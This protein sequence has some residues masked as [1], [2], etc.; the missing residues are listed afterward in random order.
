MA[1]CIRHILLH[2][3]SENTFRRS[4]KMNLDETVDSYRQNQPGRATGA[5]STD[6]NYLTFEPL[7][8]ERVWGGRK[9]AALFGR[10]LPVTNPI[11]ESW[12]LV[13]RADAQSVV[14]EGRLRGA[15]LHE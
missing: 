1:Y 11:G 3:Y 10:H 7:Y 5:S 12:E 2:T 4:R 13:D 6:A 15:A 9:L 14:S 8:M